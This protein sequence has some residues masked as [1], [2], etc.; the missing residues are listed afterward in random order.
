MRTGY[1]M[2]NTGK[3]EK[4]CS[5]FEELISYRQDLI[6]AYLGLGSSHALCGSFE[7]ASDCFTLAI[8]IDP[9]AHDAWKRRGQTRAALGCTMDAL[10]DL[11]RALEL[12]S[13]PDIYYQRGLV[14]HQMRHFDSSAQNLR[15]ALEGGLSTASLW[16]YIG[17]CEGQLGNVEASLEAHEKALEI[18]PKFKESALNLAQMLKE[19][20]R[21]VEAE[22]AFKK[23]L[24]IAS[25]SP[26][27]WYQ[28]YYY[29]SVFLH[30]VGRPRDALS[31]LALAVEA[32]PSSKEAAQYYAMA[33]NCAQALGEFDRA[34]QYFT[35]ALEVD[36]DSHYWFQREIAVYYWQKI[37]EPIGSF[38]PQEDID[39]GLKE[40]WCKQTSPSRTLVSRPSGMYNSLFASLSAIS[41]T[42]KMLPSEKMQSIKLLVELTA[43]LSKVMQLR[44]RG[45]LANAR[46]H[47]MFG[48]GKKESRYET[49]LVC[50]LNNTSNS[51]P[52]LPQPLSKPPK[53][54]VRTFCRLLKISQV[55]RVLQGPRHRSRRVNLVGATFLISLFV[56]DKYQRYCNIGVLYCSGGCQCCMI[57][58]L[59]AK[60]SSMSSTI[61]T[62][63]RV[64]LCGG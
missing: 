9:T 25:S 64:T 28:G 23:A 34:V 35:K 27:C 2:V 29:R 32:V 38:R 1:L 11:S 17:I 42:K 58:R 7:R 49:F 48:L 56:G 54:C 20:G 19:S 14:Y 59:A 50:G 46:Q 5:I 53:R 62:H 26:R 8:K 39:P 31:D 33:A 60:S 18:D 24:T 15:K 13:D 40:G 55:I 41:R 44:C 36:P 30:G 6:A 3:L 51:F 63:S 47:R 43:P 45:F 61:P 22:K 37:D 52:S 4:A 21:V 12:S 16:N 57:S 10:N